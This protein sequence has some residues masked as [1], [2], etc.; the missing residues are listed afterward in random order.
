[1]IMKRGREPARAAMPLSAP[2]S[3]LLATLLATLPGVASASYGN[4]KLTLW[5]LMAAAG[6]ALGVW[7]AVLEW[8]LVHNGGSRARAAAVKVSAMATALI[9]LAMAMTDGWTLVFLGLAAFAAAGVVAGVALDWILPS[10]RRRALLVLLLALIALVLAVVNNKSDPIFASALAPL[11]GLWGVAV[12]LLGDRAAS[13]SA[14]RSGWPRDAES[15]PSAVRPTVE[16]RSSDTVAR[17]AVAPVPL[18]PEVEARARET[19][20]RLAVERKSHSA[21]FHNPIGQAIALLASGSLLSWLLLCLLTYGLGWVIV[22]LGLPPLDALLLALAA[23]VPGSE[24]APIP[25]QGGALAFWLSF[26]LL[27]SVAL[28]SL[29]FGLLRARSR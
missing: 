28:A 24:P 11:L 18:S 4:M 16:S 5:P 21:E 14:A 26:G 2:C 13:G 1:M 17:R 12:L 3:I 23:A 7:M 6:V 15:R 25:G 9:G 19:M 29:V 27:P 10:A 8:L 22:A 20:A